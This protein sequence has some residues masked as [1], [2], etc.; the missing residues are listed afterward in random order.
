MTMYGPKVLRDTQYGDERKR[1]SMGEQKTV[2]ALVILNRAVRD[3][4]QGEVR[5]MA[6]SDPNQGVVRTRSA[7]GKP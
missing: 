2:N 5:T 1:Y 6:M 3:P 7:N 4:H